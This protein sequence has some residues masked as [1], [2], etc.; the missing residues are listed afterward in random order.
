MA[1]ANCEI[2]FVKVSF[3]S[4]SISSDNCSCLSLLVLSTNICVLFRVLSNKMRW[5]ID[6]LYTCLMKL[7]N[8]QCTFNTCN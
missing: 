3:L 8:A 2:E 1:H 6:G 7:T 4:S 5:Y